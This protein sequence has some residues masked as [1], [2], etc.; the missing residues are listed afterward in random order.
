MDLDYPTVETHYTMVKNVQP[1]K[2]AIQGVQ[3]AFHE[4]AARRF[5]DNGDI[6]V[7]PA[8]T[9]DIL[10]KKVET[11]EADAAVMA[12]ENTIAGS[13][14]RN[15][16]LLNNSNLRIR[17]EVFLRI[18]QNLMVLPDV[19]IEDLDEVHSHPVALQQCEEFFEQYPHIKLVEAHDTALVARDIRAKGWKNIGAIGSELAA[20]IYDMEILA[21]SIETYKKNFTR[22]LYITKE[23]TEGGLFP[24]FDKVSLVF[25]TNHTVGSLHKAL[26]VLARNNCN[27]TKIQSAPIMDKPWEYLFFVDFTLNNYSNYPQAMLELHRVSGEIKVLGEYESGGYFE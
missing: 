8:D 10:I 2:V 27:L 19:R 7:V 11:G 22:F 20:E 1:R 12:I 9:F 13:L 15:Y 6:E 18:K 17:G 3:G 14:L 21:P 24:K 16:N 23:N 25:V 5:H 4:I 26:E